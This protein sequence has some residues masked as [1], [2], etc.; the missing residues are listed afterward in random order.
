MLHVDDDLKVEDRIV[1]V[2]SGRPRVSVALRLC[3]GELERLL[4]RKTMEVEILKE[5]VPAA[6]TIGVLWN[7]NNR[8]HPL[9][10]DA[11]RRATER[12]DRADVQARR[13]G[14]A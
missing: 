4:G 13:I 11:A 7:Q 3:A 14:V 10:A 12:L 8:S 5:A 9:Y 1:E 2:A 6:R